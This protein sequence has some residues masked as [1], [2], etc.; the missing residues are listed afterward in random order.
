MTTDNSNVQNEC[1]Q[2]QATTRIKSIGISNPVTNGNVLRAGDPGPATPV[3]VA[4]A[5]IFSYDAD[6]YLDGVKV[7]A[8]KTDNGSGT[9][10]GNPYASP[11]AEYEAVV[12]SADAIDVPEG[13]IDRQ[14]GTWFVN[15]T[16]AANIDRDPNYTWNRI[17]AVALVTLLNA[18]GDPLPV[19]QAVTGNQFKAN[20]VDA[21][22]KA[23]ASAAQHGG[24]CREAL[25]IAPPMLKPLEVCDGWIRYSF[26][27]LSGSRIPMPPI[28]GYQLAS[29]ECCQTPLQARS[30]AVATGAI[31]WHPR[32]GRNLVITRSHGILDTSPFDG[33]TR[34]RMQ[35]DGL[36]KFCFL[37][38]Q[39]RN[40]AAEDVT[41]IPVD[42]E[43]RERPQRILLNPQ[44]P[45]FVQVNNVQDDRTKSD[46][47]L[48]FWVK[49][50][51]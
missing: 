14:N 39:L 20:P 22:F 27:S 1:S 51:S 46:G 28:N 42:A 11:E 21:T 19:S 2:N 38:H 13:N 50:L 6:Y 41:R 44:K 12:S 25:V 34:R 7:L 37:V 29:P 32:Q 4:V 35:F 45:F 8:V 48:D 15:G 23:A 47:T 36:P 30:I 49:I 24:G 9:D 16:V 3:L 17:S 31:D 18:E 33:S 26:F 5:G 43:C 10:N 40:S